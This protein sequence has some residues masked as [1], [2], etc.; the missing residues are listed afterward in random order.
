M[1]TELIEGD[2]DNKDN[3]MLMRADLMRRAGQFDELI[4]EIEGWP[5]EDKWRYGRIKRILEFVGRYI[6]K[7]LGF[8]QMNFYKDIEE[9]GD[10]F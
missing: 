7:N 2:H 3:I 9:A 1:A 8:S 10:D 5:N 4:D 6:P